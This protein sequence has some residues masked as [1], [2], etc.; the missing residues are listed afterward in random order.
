MCLICPRVGTYSES[1]VAVFLCCFFFLTSGA[2]WRTWMLRLSMRGLISKASACPSH[3]VLLLFA[4]MLYLLLTCFDT[5][6]MLYLL[7]TCWDLSKGKRM[8]FTTQLVILRHDIL[9]NILSNTSSPEPV[10]I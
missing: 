1:V 10:V 6:D 4:V 7:L 5:A 2:A 3:A 8:P 9:S